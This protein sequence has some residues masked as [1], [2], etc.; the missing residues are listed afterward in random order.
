MGNN[1]YIGI[2]RFRFFELEYTKEHFCWCTTATTE[3]PFPRELNKKRNEI[4]DKDNQA[5]LTQDECTNFA[6]Y[7]SQCSDY[8]PETSSAR[9]TKERV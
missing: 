3:T 9:R 6:P 4:R 7:C 2:Q 5:I 1:T 8:V